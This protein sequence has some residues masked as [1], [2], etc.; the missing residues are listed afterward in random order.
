[1]HIDPLK[2]RRRRKMVAKVFFTALIATGIVTVTG[3]QTSRTLLSSNQC[4][5]R[6]QLLTKHINRFTSIDR[7]NGK[8]GLHVTPTS[9]SVA[10][11]A[12][13]AV[14]SQYHQRHRHY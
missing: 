7:N 13:A 8:N 14:T 3:F 1:M 4:R 5:T 11:V 9:A 2:I 12:T 10:E 6:Q